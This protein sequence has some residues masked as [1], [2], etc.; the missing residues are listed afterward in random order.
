VY[1]LCV[2]LGLFLSLHAG[3]AFSQKVDN[4]PMRRV[5]SFELKE[6]PLEL[7]AEDIFA[8]TGCRIVFDEKWKDLPLSGQYTDVTLEEFFLRALRK[9]NVSL[10][11]DDKKNEVKLHFFGDRKNGSINTGALTSSNTSGVQVSEEIKALHNAQRVEMDRLRNDP[12]AID[13]ASGMTNAEIKKLHEGQQAEMDRLRNDPKAIDIASSMTNAEIRKLHEGQQAE[14][15][16]LRNDPNAIDLASGMTNAEI[17]KLHE[18]QRAELDRLRNDPNA[19]DLVS[20]M[21]NAEI[22]KLHERQRAELGQL[23]KK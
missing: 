8:Q 15:D 19:I 17:K 22:K 2:V 10:S 1:K 6:K 21:T 3:Q 16:R 12:N 13:L 23:S 18:K 5:I 9:Q 11:Y 20:G 7:I 4:V 14:M